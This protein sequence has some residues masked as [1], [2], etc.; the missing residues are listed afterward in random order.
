MRRAASGAGR[1]A[2]RRVRATSWRSSPTPTS[3][4][5]R[6]RVLGEADVR[7]LWGG[8]ETIARL[9]AVPAGPAA[10]RPHVRR[11]LLVR[12]AASGRCAEADDQ[13]RYTLAERLFNDA[14]WF[15]QLGCSSPRLIV[16]VGAED[17]VDRAREALF[18]ELARGHRRQAVPPGARR[19]A[20]EAHLHLRRAD[21]PAGRERV[22]GR[23]TSC[24][25]S[26]LSDLD[27]FDRTH[28]GA[29]LFFDARVDALADLVAFVRRKDQTLTAHGFPTEEL[30]AL[31]AVAARPRPRSD[32][33]VRRRAALRQP[34]GRL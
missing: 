7:L 33:P 8:D 34:L 27:G 5:P 24:P 18:A 17:E 12:G 6:P 1:G 28:P 15:D 19:R 23:A 4:S 30:T 14:Y 29:G 21:R 10:A 22:P 3:R 9:R 25:C 20:R 16:W 13:P 26:A 32:R 11:P 2:V 31:R